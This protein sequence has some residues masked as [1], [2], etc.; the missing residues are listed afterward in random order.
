MLEFL[1]RGSVQV[2]V[3]GF[4]RL[5]PQGLRVVTSCAGTASAF[6]NAF[7][8][9]D[10]DNI[11]A[12]IGISSYKFA[13]PTFPGRAGSFAYALAKEGCRSILIGLPRFGFWPAAIPPKNMSPINC[14]S[15]NYRPVIGLP[16]PLRGIRAKDFGACKC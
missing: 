13:E 11:T 10:Y 9:N 7:G 1:S 6:D 3:S 4:N 16:F 8:G 15:C 14:A 2:H 12:A 5:S